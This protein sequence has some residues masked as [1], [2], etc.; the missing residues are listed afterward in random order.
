MTPKQKGK[1]GS[2]TSGPEGRIPPLTIENAKL[3]YKNF[4]GAAKRFNAAGLRNFNVVLDLETAKMLQNDGWNIKFDDPR[5]EGDPP[6]A[7]MKVNF[8]FDNYPP[9]IIMISG[10]DS[11]A[12]TLL[13]AETVGILDWAD[14]QTVDITVSGSRW[15]KG[16]DHGIKTWLRKMI[17][18]LSPNDIESKYMVAP[19][20]V[21]NIDQED[22]N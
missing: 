19:K 12:Q 18:T 2:T 22:D 13:N 14:I 16:K 21:N 5:E 20:L 8:S 7:R 11:R 4:A 17:V 10:R 15:E 9:R 3:I 6:I 1:S